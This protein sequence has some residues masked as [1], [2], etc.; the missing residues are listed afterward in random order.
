MT[1]GKQQGFD[2][3]LCF[4]LF[5]IHPEHKSTHKHK[6]KIES[7]CEYAVMVHSKRFFL[8]FFSHETNLKIAF[9]VISW[10]HF[11]DN[12]TSS[13]QI[14]SRTC[15]TQWCLETNMEEFL[16]FPDVLEVLVVSLIIK[17]LQCHHN[18][19][20]TGLLQDLECFYC[21]AFYL[22]LVLS[23]C[24]LFT[25]PYSQDFRNTEVMSPS[26]LLYPT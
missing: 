22:E 15:R 16:I 12:K 20:I 18:S 23:V 2:A 17:Y 5:L 14:S 8:F 4:D 6:Y 24:C 19:V 9:V 10:T 26:H 3:C 13:Q 11:L 7:F 25:G 21:V 1:T